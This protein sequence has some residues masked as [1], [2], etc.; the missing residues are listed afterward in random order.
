M[1]TTIDAGKRK[2]ITMISISSSSFCRRASLTLP[3]TDEEALKHSGQ[4]RLPEWHHLM[5]PR[6]LEGLVVSDCLD[7][8]AEDE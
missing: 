4:L 7:T 5:F 1:L 6:V 3:V 8:P 2:K